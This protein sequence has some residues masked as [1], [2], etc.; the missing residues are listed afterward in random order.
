MNRFLLFFTLSICFV[1]LAARFFPHL[2]NFTPVGALAL[3]VGA[4]L[5]PK[6]KWALLLPL[7]ILFL[8]DVFIGFYEAQIMALVYSSFLLYG[9]IGFLV[10]RNKNPLAIIGGTFGGALLFFLVTNFGVWAFSGLYEKSFAGLVNAYLLAIPFFR[11][12]LLGD[13]AYTG[14]FFGAYEIL[15]RYEGSRVLSLEGVEKV[16][17]SEAVADNHRS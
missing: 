9:A 17:F 5:A 10:S 13:L 6:T 15:L 12:T 1:A 16:S 2:P 8:S 7:P 3:F 14:L 4:Y 11:S